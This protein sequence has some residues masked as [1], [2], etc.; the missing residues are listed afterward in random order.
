MYCQ[1]VLACTWRGWMGIVLFVGNALLHLLV[2]RSLHYDDHLSKPLC[3]YDLVLSSCCCAA[4]VCGWSVGPKVSRG[5]GRR[6]KLGSLAYAPLWL[7]W[8]NVR[9][10]DPC[11]WPL[12]L[13]RA[14]IAWRLG[15]YWTTPHLSISYDRLCYAIATTKNVVSVCDQGLAYRCIIASHRESH[16]CEFLGP[17]T[18]LLVFELP[19]IA[20]STTATYSDMGSFC[21][22]VHDFDQ[23]SDLFWSRIQ[24]LIWGVYELRS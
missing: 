21:R 23:I 9:I 15:R 4:S 19:V 18:E 5:S 16:Y 8:S 24:F 20:T 22:L 3:A 2:K 11:R 1:R 17:S 13:H 14:A 6:R 7:D 12:K 10:I